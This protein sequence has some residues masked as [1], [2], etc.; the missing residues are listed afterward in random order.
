MDE[1]QAEERGRAMQRELEEDDSRSVRSMSRA[2]GKSRAREDSINSFNQMPNGF[3]SHQSNGGTSVYAM[4]Q[5]APSRAGSPTVC[6]LLPCIGHTAYICAQ[7]TIMGFRSKPKPPP[8]PYQSCGD[9]G[10]TACLLTALKTLT[11]ATSKP[12]S[13]AGA[14]KSKPVIVPSQPKA[15]VPSSGPFAQQQQYQP[16]QNQQQFQQQNHQ[17]GFTNQ[18]QNRQ[19]QASRP[20]SSAPAPAA[21]SGSSRPRAVSVAPKELLQPVDFG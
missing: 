6:H 10:C 19:R 4:S 1:Y 8:H 2:R 7:G 17:N 21:S 9:D 14:V 3:G 13:N 12:L 20:A 18:N 16:Q 5:Y 15:Q 11:Q